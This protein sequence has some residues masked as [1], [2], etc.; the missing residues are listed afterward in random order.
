MFALP[1]HIADFGATAL[2]AMLVFSGPNGSLRFIG[3]L[4]KDPPQG[5]R[6]AG[7]VAV[8]DDGKVITRTADEERPTMAVMQEAGRRYMNSLRALGVIQTN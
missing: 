7:I 6:L 8:F 4:R 2:C 3:E 5:Y 1:K